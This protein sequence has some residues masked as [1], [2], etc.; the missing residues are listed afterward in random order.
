MA[1]VS[2]Q[3]SGVEINAVKKFTRNFKRFTEN[4]GSSS[5]YDCSR[6]GKHHGPKQCPAFG[7]KCHICSMAGHFSKM[8]RR[9]RKKPHR[10]SVHQ[11]EIQSEEEQEFYV[12]GAETWN[13]MVTINNKIIPMM[14]DTGAQCN[15]MSVTQFKE[16]KLPRSSIKP[17]NVKLTSYCGNKIDVIGQC[18][19]TC[20]FKNVSNHVR[21]FICNNNQRA[22]LG[23]KTCQDLELI[24]KVNSVEVEHSSHNQS[25]EY[26]GLLNKYQDI[27]EGLGN[28]PGYCKIELRENASPH[29]DPPRRVPF[30]LLD[31]YKKELEHMVELG[32]IQKIAT[33]PTE[34]VNSAVIIEKASGGLRVCLD[35]RELN[36]EIV[37][38]RFV[39]P[40]IE[41]IRSKLHGATKFSVLDASTAFWAVKLD[42]Q[43]SKLCTF[44]TPF[45]R[46]KFLRLPYGLSCAPEKFHQKVVD[47]MSDIPGVLVYIDDILIYG[48]TKEEHN[49]RLQQVLN[50]VREINLK[51]NKAKCKI[52]VDKVNFLGHCFQS[53]GMSPDESKVEAIQQIP[54]PTSVVEL[55]R[56]LGMV[57]YLGSY[58]PNLSEKTHNLRKLLKKDNIWS[59]EKGH[60]DEFKNLKL[61]L[62]S[63]PVLAFYNVNDPIVLTTDSSKDAVG[64]AILQKGKVIA[65]ASKTLTESQKSWAQ[66]E[67]E[68]F[69]IWA[70]CEKFHQYVYGQSV[71]CE[72]DH[73]P[74]I[75]LFKKP[76]AVV[77]SRL[78]RLML[79]L[80]KYDL[81][82]VYKSGKE[83]YI[84]DTLSRAACSSQCDELE[85]SL[86]SDLAVHC[87]FFIN[88]LNVSEEKFESIRQETI[89]DDCLKY[90]I[91][92]F[93]EGWPKHKKQVH[94]LAQEFYPFRNEIHVLDNVVFKDTSIVIPKKLQKEMLEKIHTSHMGVARSKNLVKGIIFWPRIWDEIKITCQNCQVCIKYK[95]NNQKEPLLP[96]ELPSYAWE[97]IGVDLFEFNKKKYL[98]LVDYYSKFFELSILNNSNSH[99][100]ITQF[101]SVFS[102]QGIPKQIVS[103]RGPPFDSMELRQFYK[104]WNIVHIQSS[105]YYPKS[106]GLVERTIGTVKR[107]LIKCLETKGDPYLAMLH[108]RN[109]YKDGDNSPSVL[110][111]GRKLRTN[112]PTANKVLQ[113]KHVSHKHVKQNYDK[114]VSTMKHYYDRGA[115]PLSSLELYQPVVYQK[116]PGAVWSPAVVSKTPA[117]TGTPR[118]YEIKTSDGATY[119]RNRVHLSPNGSS[120][121]SPTLSTTSDFK[122]S[123]TISS[124]Q[125][126]GSVGPPVI[127][128][129][130]EPDNNKS[131]KLT[132]EKSW[133]F[134]QRKDIN[135]KV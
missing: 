33:E 92:Y 48:S 27:F 51:L 69:S 80:Q 125:G 115:K 101:K 6:C 5:T 37:R 67:K 129:P 24:K 61:A 84:A 54:Q 76:L 14:L 100:I 104:A 75:T 71:T 120:D 133:E 126:A 111:N 124:P 79:K 130:Q 81:K 19:I 70:G 66:I 64:A 135:Y 95:P 65:Y 28:L 88:S 98:L 91:K 52:G 42:E 106:N 112:I 9:R 60:D 29:V 77:P 113:S 17:V 72:T 55:Q 16:L 13:V 10:N 57:N 132:F 3:D 38:S 119:V 108:L 117:Q 8:C 40:T 1:N 123:P 97:K 86:E 56:F 21:F 74:L 103:D 31:N 90:V 12:V 83:M 94:R 2:G 93:Q 78:Q 47:F 96:H 105:P 102:R 7:A 122:M 99:S 35:P 73:K 89:K 25:D 36:K 109:T 34:W 68:L 46:F 49:N 63:A 107:T 58:I 43:S 32:V 53:T 127:N 50:R 26:S 118:S 15:L 62:T 30:V 23:L 85:K 20:K 87:N 18:I 44:N 114:K 45:A 82:V 59:W 22:I 41:D 134:R 110:L 4:Q 128:S 39:L 11:V 131:R 116:H 121:L